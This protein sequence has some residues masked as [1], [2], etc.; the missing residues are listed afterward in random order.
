MKAC[1]LR[2][3]E[4]TPAG[5]WEIKAE[6][7]MEVI[8]LLRDNSAASDHMSSLTPTSC[9]N[10]SVKTT[11]CNRHQHLPI[12]YGPLPESSSGGSHGVVAIRRDHKCRV[13]GLLARGERGVRRPRGRHDAEGRGALFRGGDGGGV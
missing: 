13:G 4:L 12:V 2:E 1:K 5:R 10:E 3:R 7:T 8:S 6:T 9:V 11:H